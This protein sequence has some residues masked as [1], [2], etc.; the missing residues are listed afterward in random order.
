VVYGI[1]TESLQLLV[2]QRTARVMDGVENIL[3]IA[4]GAG[5]YWLALR[6]LGR[7]IAHDAP[8]E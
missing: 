1:T 6:T 5:I 8:A 7:Q 4:A 3:G 2:P